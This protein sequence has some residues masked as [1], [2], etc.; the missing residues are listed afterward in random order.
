MAACL[1]PHSGP[2]LC[3]AVNEYFFWD[4]INPTQAALALVAH[5]AAPVLAQQ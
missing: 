3:Q 5:A 1:A 2:F 4:G